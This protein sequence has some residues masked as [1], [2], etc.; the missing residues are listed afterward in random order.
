MMDK[1]LQNDEKSR[2]DFEAYLD[3]WE[4][5]ADVKDFEKVNIDEDWSKVRSRMSFLPRSRKIPLRKYGMQIAAIFILAIGLAFFLSQV[6]NKAKLYSPEYYE[7]VSA[8]EIQEIKLPDGSIV[9]LNKNGKLFRNSEF[10]KTNR[11]IILEG[12]AFFNVSRNEDLP[13]KIHTMNST[14][15][16]LGTSFNVKSDTDLIIVSVM[17]G[18]VAFYLNDDNETRLELNADNAGE[19]NP[20]TRKLELQNSFDPNSIVW[21]TK[22]FIFKDT[23]FFKVCEVIADYYH[24]KLRIDPELHNDELI[25]AEIS[26]DSINHVISEIYLHL[27]DKDIKLI[28][29]E[30]N[31]IVRKL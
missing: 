7:I 10:G 29:T 11:D 13:F 14:V 24:L 27:E 19:L 26:T 2:K 5:S 12:E 18:K 1:R 4:K 31:L 28:P 21:Y 9:S 17:T 8:G 16:V 22:E 6:L 3:V 20:Q 23:P 25:K 15:E 30:K